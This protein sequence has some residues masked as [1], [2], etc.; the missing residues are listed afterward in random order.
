MP[1]KITMK[2]P[3]RENSGPRPRYLV[4]DVIMAFLDTDS[5]MRFVRAVD[6][7]RSVYVQRL[8]SL[9]ILRIFKISR[10]FLQFVSCDR[11]AINVVIYT[12]HIE[13]RVLYLCAS[14]HFL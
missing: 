14:S 5:G 3:F 6:Q 10:V 12:S 2:S 13:S 8:A 9:Q 1:F 4:S 11:S 7:A